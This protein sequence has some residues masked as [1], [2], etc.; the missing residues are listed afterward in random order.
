MLLPADDMYKGGLG[1]N[2]EGFK[3]C[4]GAAVGKVTTGQPIKFTA[5]PDDA[6]RPVVYYTSREGDLSFGN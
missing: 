3:A 1:Y 4:L 2:S 6:V 5:I